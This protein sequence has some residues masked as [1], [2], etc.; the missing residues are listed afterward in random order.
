MQSDGEEVT[1]MS[2]GAPWL[3]LLLS[4]LAAPLLA[5]PASAPEPSP[6]E[7][8]W[9]DWIVV[10]ETPEPGASILLRRIT[11]KSVFIAP[12]LSCSEGYRQDALGRCVKHVK[13]NQAEHW[14]FYL[15]RLNSMYAPATNKKPQKESGPFHIN[16]PIGSEKPQENIAVHKRI[17]PPPA[18]TTQSTTTSTTSTTTTTTTTTPAPTTTTVEP[19]TMEVTQPTVVD[20]SEAP[21]YDLQASDI[22]TET[23][24]FPGTTESPLDT[25]VMLGDQSVPTSTDQPTDTTT[26]EPKNH[27]PSQAPFVII[28]TNE[29]TGESTFE[30]TTSSTPMEESATEEPLDSTTER[31]T[32]DSTTTDYDERFSESR[33]VEQTS[34]SPPPSPRPCPLTRLSDGSYELTECGDQEVKLESYKRV[35]TVPPELPYRVP[36]IVRFPQEPVR[37]TQDYV[38]F[39][40]EYYPHYN[41]DWVV[42][43][44]PVMQRQRTDE[45]VQQ[46][47]FQPQRLEGVQHTPFQSEHKLSFSDWQKRYFQ[48][49]QEDFLRRQRLRAY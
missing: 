15:D 18:S 29:P 39:P 28:V 13:V 32:T 20:T 19:S 41:P 34:P 33:D 49:N 45:G 14:K 25:S 22:T 16:L 5:A 38:R 8:T 37:K 36:L 6:P 11:P 44:R 9:G 35:V 43:R 21:E 40:D 26:Q 3:W 4:L 23:R 27:Y 7:A 12:T 17:P 47:P 42:R 1:G 46:T 31:L 48:I 24:K 30:P 2:A 10:D